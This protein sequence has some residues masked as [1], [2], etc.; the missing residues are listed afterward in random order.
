[1]LVHPKNKENCGS[2]EIFVTVQVPYKSAIEYGLK[3]TSRTTERTYIP[4]LGIEGFLSAFI[5]SYEKMP[6]LGYL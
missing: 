1:M 6:S 2:L 3:L 5:C 4:S